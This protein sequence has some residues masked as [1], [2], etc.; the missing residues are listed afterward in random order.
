MAAG[1]PSSF[2][3]TIYLVTCYLD[4]LPV[5]TNVVNVSS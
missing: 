1:G 5:E 2:L 4:K 3:S